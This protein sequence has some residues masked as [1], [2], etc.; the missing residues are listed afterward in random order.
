MH[1]LGRGDVCCTL[2]LEHIVP[3]T[4]PLLQERFHLVSDNPQKEGSYAHLVH[5]MKTIRS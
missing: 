1:S 2:L 3:L 4:N 5:L